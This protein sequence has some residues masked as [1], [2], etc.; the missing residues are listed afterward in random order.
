EVG[1]CVSPS[2]K[3]LCLEL[4]RGAVG[5]VGASVYLNYHG[6]TVLGRFSFHLGGFETGRINQPA[7]NLLAIRGCVAEF[8]PC[9]KL[10]LVHELFVV[11]CKLLRCRSLA[12]AVYLNQKQVFRLN[13]GGLFQDDLAGRRRKPRDGYVRGA[14]QAPEVPARSE[15]HTS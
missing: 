8:F 15:E 6:E 14:A 9:S 10:H 13:R 3:Q 7:V 12:A 11:K 4:K 5:T 2:C 1:Y